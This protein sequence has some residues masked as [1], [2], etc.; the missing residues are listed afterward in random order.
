MHRQGLGPEERVYCLNFPPPDCRMRF[1]MARK[2]CVHMPRLLAL[3]ALTDSHARPGARVSGSATDTATNVLTPS[4]GQEGKWLASTQAHQVRAPWRRPAGV[5]LPAVQ[6]EQH[7][8]YVPALLCPA[9]QARQ[10]HCQYADG[11]NILG[12]N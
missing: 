12:K 1:R 5:N 9:H 11:F 10:G 3:L 4:R 7:A 6:E 8:P 2:S